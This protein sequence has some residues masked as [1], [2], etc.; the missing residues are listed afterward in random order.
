MFKLDDFSPLEY[1]TMAGEWFA[2]CQ[3]N[4]VL[5]SSVQ[6]WLA[7]QEEGTI[8]L[9]KFRKNP[10]NGTASHPER[11]ETSASSLWELQILCAENW[12]MQNVQHT[13][14]IYIYNVTVNRVCKNTPDGFWSWK[15]ACSLWGT[16]ILT[17]IMY[18]DVWS[19]C[20]TALQQR[21][22]L[23]KQSLLQLHSM[24]SDSS[25]KDNVPSHNTLLLWL[26][27]WCQ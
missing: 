14:I 20:S 23:W 13:Y 3:R 22:Y 16:S 25:S 7:F 6:D 10:P 26:S 5:S 21:N 9:H 2:I 15:P 18:S 17:V 24:V 8:V 12:F 4:A 1:N 27:K 11:P 19:Q